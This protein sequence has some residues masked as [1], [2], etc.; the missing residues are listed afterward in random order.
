MQIRSLSINTQ[1]FNTHATQYSC[2]HSYSN[3]ETLFIKKV[4]N[5]KCFL[6]FLVHNEMAEKETVVLPSLNQRKLKEGFHTEKESVMQ[7]SLYERRIKEGFHTEKESVIQPSLY[8][9]RFSYK[10]RRFSFEKLRE[11]LENREGLKKVTV[12]AFLI[13]DTK[14]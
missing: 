10:Q 4:C 5:P 6:D 14:F 9:R 7:P 13:L 11:G 12:P 3:K 8:E 1:E 2:N